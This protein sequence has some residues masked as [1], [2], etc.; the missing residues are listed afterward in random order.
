MGTKLRKAF[1]LFE[2][3]VVVMIIGVVYALVLGSFDPKKSIKVITLKDI[4]SALSPHWTKGKKIDLYIYDRC[5]KSALFINDEIKD[6]IK[7]N[8]DSNLFKNIKVYKTAVTGDRREIKFTPVI[9]DNRVK[10]VCFQYTI[11]PNG[12][13]SSYIIKSGKNYYVYFPYFENTYVTT[14]FDEA[15][16]RY[17]NS[18]F[19]KITAHE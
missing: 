18:E 2:L 19:T 13:S 6:D 11:F 12:S 3:M 17:Q 5:K 16:E 10:K 8:I 9:I 1:T 7:V 15:K 14:D 4:R